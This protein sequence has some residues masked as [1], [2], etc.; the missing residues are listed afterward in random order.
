MKLKKWVKFVLLIILLS[1]IFLFLYKIINNNSN[2]KEEEKVIEINIVDTL[3]EKLKDKDISYE[4]LVWINDN[5]KDSLNKLNTLLETNTYEDSMWHNITGNSYIVLNDLYNKKYDSMDNVK[6]VESRNPSVLSFVGDV[7]LADNWYIMPKYDERGKKVYGILSDD[8]VNTMNNSDLMVVNSEFTVSNRGTKMN[9]K[10]YTFR[11]NPKRLTIYD[12]MGVDLVT[13][14]NNHVYDFG[15]DAFLDMLDSFD[16][17]KIP[18]IGAGKNIEE[19]MKP[20]YFVINGYKFAFVNATRAE[21]Y[22]MTPEAGEDSPG[23]FRCYNPTNMVN[24]IT[25]VKKESDYVIAIIHFGK[26]G[27]HE[28]EE[29]QVKSAKMY[30]DAGASAV[31]GH[32]AH[33]LQGIEFYNNKP[34]IYNLGDFIFNGDKEET[35]MFQIK[36]NDDGTMEYYILPALQRDCYTD[37]LEG[38][39]K[40]KLIDKIISWSINANIDENGKITE[41]N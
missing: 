13:L 25:E 11:A 23:V 26:E 33:V 40:Q 31:I 34:I 16:E 28:L 39:E 3:Y 22:I 17:Y 8:V 38:D 19:A 10:Q 1:S 4:F 5:Y 6:I 12:E 20:Y 27:Y 36:L 35:A 9:G 30:I 7:S 15:R 18:R 21:K 24:L 2:E 37:F 32:H 29:E 14:A 41:K